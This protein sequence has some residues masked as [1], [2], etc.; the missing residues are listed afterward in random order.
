[1]LNKLLFKPIVILLLF[2]TLLVLDYIIEII[3]PCISYFYSQVL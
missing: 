1:M 2:E 3:L